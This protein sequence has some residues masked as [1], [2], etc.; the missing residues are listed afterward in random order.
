MAKSNSKKKYDWFWTRL[1]QHLEA[2]QLKQTKQRQTIVEYF[3]DLNKHISAEELY[4]YVRKKGHNTGLATVYRTLN[5]LKEAG[6]ALQKN[7]ADGKAVYEI[8]QPDS[9]HDHLICL[10][11]QE[12]VE[13]ENDEIE[14]IQ[15]QVAKSFGYKLVSHTHELYGI[16]K[17]CTDDG[18]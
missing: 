17:K 7:F 5:L 13:F 11:C 10:K 2:K 18:H 8:N 16:C 14:S 4:D 9:H 3:I 1:D 12:V 6:L 15:E